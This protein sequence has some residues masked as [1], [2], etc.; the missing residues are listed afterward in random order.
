[1]A[2]QYFFIGNTHFTSVLSVTDPSTLSD[3][4][5]VDDENAVTFTY[6]RDGRPSGEAYIAV[7]S[8]DDQATALNHNREHIGSRYIEG[9][10]VCVYWISD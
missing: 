1:M 7:V 2:N 3:V 10:P 5:V 4:H 9:R 8:A 6:T